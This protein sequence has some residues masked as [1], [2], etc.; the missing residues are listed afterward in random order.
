MAQRRVLAVD[1]GGTRI[2]AAVVGDGVDIGPLGFADTPPDAETA[3]AAVRRLGAELAQGAPL[4]G[5]GLCVPGLVD[6]NGR[7]VALPGKLDGIVGRDLPAELA[8]AFGARPVVVNDA[9][10]YGAGEALAGAGAGASRVVV[11]TIGTGVGVTVFED[12]RPV[13]RGPLG[14]GIQGGQIPIAAGDP[15]H[16]DT[17][18]HH[19]TLEACCRAQRI[20]DYAVDAG[21]AYDSVE[22]VYAAAAAGAAPAVAG[23]ERY[24]AYLVLAVRA[25]ANAHGAE[26]VVVGGGPVTGTDP[27][28]DGVEAAV[29]RELWP[30]HQLSVR[31]ASLGDAAALVGL[32]ELQSRTPQ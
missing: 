28:L 16:L 26:V 11:M 22:A 4:T 15:R 5:I 18:D 2:K 3:L 32:A 14:A 20:V 23:I 17:S 29:Q 7:I 24:R 8:A 13:S 10:A 30:T 12:G 9:V 25:L 21:G 6:D 1:V 31:R 27:L 19:D